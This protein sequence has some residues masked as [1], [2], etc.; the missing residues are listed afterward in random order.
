[1]FN[2]LFS[3]A[4]PFTNNAT[5]AHLLTHMVPVPLG[6]S[7]PSSTINLPDQ[8]FTNTSPSQNSKGHQPAPNQPIM[9]NTPSSQLAWL[10]NLT[11]KFTDFTDEQKYM[12][13]VRV[14]LTAE[15]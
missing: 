10:S 12:R 5:L 7:P 2:P 14:K 1:M 4:F 9:S 13:K 8:P 6:Y 3:T 11:T 15:M